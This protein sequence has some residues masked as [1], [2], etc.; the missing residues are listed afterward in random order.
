[1]SKKL[2]YFTSLVLVLSLAGKGWSKASN[3]DPRNGALFPDT[4]VTLSWQ[5]GDLAV[6]FDIY[7]DENYD[8]VKY[9]TGGTFRGNQSIMFFIVGFPGF[10]YT[11]GLVPG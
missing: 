11:D 10:P 5:P 1:M 9:G 6:S 2:I 7:V 3:P 4:W 8:D